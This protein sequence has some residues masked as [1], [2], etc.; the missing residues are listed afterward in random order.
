MPALD[1][2]QHPPVATPDQGA[3]RLPDIVDRIEAALAAD[4]IDEAEFLA[5]Q[6]I[7]SFP[8]EQEAWRRWAAVATRRNAW[9][10]A[11]ERWTEV[12]RRYPEDIEGILGHAQALMRNGQQGEAELLAGKAVEQFPESFRLWNIWAA[13][14]GTRGAWAE[15]AARWIKVREHFP[16][17]V[18]S[19]LQGARA[20]LQAG[21]G[22][23]AERL[24]E[25][26]RQR[27]PDDE[28]GWTLWLDVAL[29][30]KDWAAV[31]V[32]AQAQADRLGDAAPAY[33]TILK[34]A[35]TGAG[36]ASVPELLWKLAFAAADQE[37]G[38]SDVPTRVQALHLLRDAALVIQDR[39]EI[40]APEERYNL[41]SSMVH[42]EA[43]TYEGRTR[44]AAE[45]GYF[46]LPCDDTTTVRVFRNIDLDWQRNFVG[47]TAQ[48]LA[49]VFDLRAYDSARY[50]RRATAPYMVFAVA[51]KKVF[52]IN[53]VP[54]DHQSLEFIEKYFPIFNHI[55][56]K[57]CHVAIRWLAMTR[58]TVEQ[59][60]PVAIF[61]THRNH[62]GHYVW[63]TIG[64]IN[65]L[66]RNDALQG[67][68][69]IYRVNL[70]EGFFLDAEFEKGLVGETLRDKIRFVNGRRFNALARQELILFHESSELSVD[71]ADRMRAQVPDGTLA[72]R[73]KV[74]VEVRKG[75]RD[76]ANANDCYVAALTL[77][78]KRHPD[79]HVVIDGFCPE[80]A[81]SPGQDYVHSYLEPSHEAAKALKA[82]LTATGLFTD[83]EIISLVGLPLMRQLAELKDCVLAV[84][85]HAGG[86]VKTY[87][88]LQLPQY[89]IAAQS[90]I[91]N[92]TRHERI[93][94][95]N[96]SLHDRGGSD[97]GWGLGTMYTGAD[98]ARLAP[99]KTVDLANVLLTNNGL[100]GS[101]RLD[102][103][104]FAGGFA[105][106]FDFCLAWCRTNG[107]IA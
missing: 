69:A 20:H 74:A 39:G 89:T 70:D 106:Y 93:F 77:L 37:L 15:G 73:L 86:Y 98:V 88:L 10:E 61:I 35:A 48:G 25:E 92:I 62:F 75:S 68:T 26:V 3:G 102:P 36:A 28:Q 38:D 12:R 54:E 2:P 50:L 56:R 65:R 32:R 4:A 11:V 59:P 52:L 47:T 41:W 85:A 82:S 53:F 103:E 107:R 99:A 7:D 42:D 6:L 80:T 66:S 13:V 45:K 78:K 81:K 18:E 19:Y 101:F 83:E 30:R 31:A 1:T 104:G 94:A 96:R 67:L 55:I 49:V 71:M 22:A 100:R 60:L 64:Q 90:L 84:N 97:R 21:D 5:G 16:G 9:S 8:E 29:Q 46:T 63:N 23:A 58:E 34:D 87:W 27:F 51:E 44:E 14:P 33:A 95:G 72:G 76:L 79:L 43:F 40:V 57:I 105:D 24:A 17:R 91:Q